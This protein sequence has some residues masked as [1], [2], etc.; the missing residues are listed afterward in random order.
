V[1][2]NGEDRRR[3]LHPCRRVALRCQNGRDTLIYFYCFIPCSCSPF[4][5]V[6]VSRELACWSL[7]KMEEEPVS[8]GDFAPN[9]PVHLAYNPSYSACFFSCNSIFFS[10][11]NQSTVFFNRLIIPVERGQCLLPLALQFLTL[12]TRT[13][14]MSNF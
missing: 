10:Q 3:P 13:R 6:P 8:C 12:W 14:L 4:G 9:D 2:R 11:K 5:I 7:P 1:G